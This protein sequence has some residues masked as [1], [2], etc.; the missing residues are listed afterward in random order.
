VKGI[1]TPED[2]RQ[3]VDAGADGLI[4]S[5]HGDRQLDRCPVSIPAL[6]EV[7]KEARPDI[8]IILDSGE[9]S[10]ADIVAALGL[11]ADFIFVGRAYLYGLMAGGEQC[12]DKIIELLAEEAGP[13][14][15]AVAGKRRREHRRL[16]IDIYKSSSRKPR[17]LF[18]PLKLRVN[19]PLLLSLPG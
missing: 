18:T 8:E 14:H 6:S 5:N 16:K 2:T 17:G 10:G 9:V 7:R 12:V 13:G 15:R 19:R 1:L 11:G 3:A 4:V